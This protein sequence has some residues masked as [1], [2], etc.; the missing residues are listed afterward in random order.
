M[1]R[2][3]GSGGGG[4]GRGGDRSVFSFVFRS[5]GGGTTIH[6]VISLN[7]SGADE[8][9]TVPFEETRILRQG[10]SYLCLVA[11]LCPSLLLPIVHVSYCLCGPIAFIGSHFS[12]QAHHMFFFS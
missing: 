10:A 2:L 5:Q 11:R 9:R 4:E 1:Y 12:W 8:V 7:I 6:L 3:L